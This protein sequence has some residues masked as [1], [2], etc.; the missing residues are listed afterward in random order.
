M[1]QKL[2]Y[3]FNIP[4]LVGLFLIILYG[5]TFLYYRIDLTA[6]KRYSLTPATKNLLNELDTTINVQV[7]LTGELPED[8]K[9]LNLA[10]KELLEEFR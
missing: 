1:Q 2:K 9:K 3:S 6:E 8:Y 7:F 10:T 4:V 5:S